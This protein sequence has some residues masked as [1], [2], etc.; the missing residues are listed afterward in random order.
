LGFSFIV[1]P[2]FNSKRGRIRSDAAAQYRLFSNGSGKKSKEKLSLKPHEA[3]GL[4]LQTVNVG[5]SQA[6]VVQEWCAEVVLFL[7]PV[8][9]SF[10]VTGIVISN[11]KNDERNCNTN[12]D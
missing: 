1:A 5:G 4:S 9:R 6:A 8:S 12:P 10:A 7:H 11:K 2:Y 3:K